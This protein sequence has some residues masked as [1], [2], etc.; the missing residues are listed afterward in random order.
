MTPHL[1]AHLETHDTHTRTLF[2]AA[3]PISYNDR[4]VLQI[5]FKKLISRHTM[6]DFIS[7]SKERGLMI[8]LEEHCASVWGSAVTKLLAPYKTD[9]LSI[10]MNCKNQ[11]H[12]RNNW[13][14]LHSVKFGNQG[15]TITGCCKISHCRYFNKYFRFSLDCLAK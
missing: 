9:F 13:M 7:S 10:M 12:S 5:L 14:H 3:R 1:H 15:L 11:Y 4:L 8:Q 6:N 2:R